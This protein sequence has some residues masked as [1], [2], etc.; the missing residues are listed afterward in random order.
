MEKKLEK[1]FYKSSKKGIILMAIIILISL[2]FVNFSS[3]LDNQGTGKQ[4]DNFTIIQACE[5]ATY[6]TLDG[7]LYPD[8]TFHELNINM[9][10]TGSGTFAYNFTDTI[11]SG[12]YD[13]SETSDGCEKTF[14]YYFEI[15]P[16]GMTLNSNSGWGIIGSIVMMII[17]ALSFL[18]IANKSDSI[19]IKVTFYSL[20]GIFFI[21]LILYT[22]VIMQ[23]TLFG[24]ESILSSIETFWFIV[25]VLIIIGILS[26][27]I[28]VVMII[29][30]AWKIKRGYTDE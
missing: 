18:F 28:I 22:V 3:A 6:V 13:V 2:C 11:Q 12:R 10:M 23:Q 25:K 26:L 7:V 21:L 29:F 14:A 17:V 24:F 9:T 8:K 5:D 30:K 16:S 4:G 19:G 15:T 1:K 20:S 27:L